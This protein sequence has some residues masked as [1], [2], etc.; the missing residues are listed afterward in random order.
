MRDIIFDEDYIFPGSMEYL[1][2]KL[3][4]IELDKL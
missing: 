3:Q 4:D 2:D 1:K